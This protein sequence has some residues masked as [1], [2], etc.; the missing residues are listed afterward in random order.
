[1]TTASPALALV[2]TMS[3]VSSGCSV[4]FMDRAPKQP[5]P[6][7]FP[8]C[9]DSAAAP[10]VDFLLAGS[11]LSS[12]LATLADRADS[13]EGF[14]QDDKVAI[15]AFLALSAA[16]IASGIYGLHVRSDC[17]AA[18]S[19]WEDTRRF[20]APHPAPPIPVGSRGG[21]CYGNNT[22]NPGFFCHP[23]AHIC[24][25]GSNG[26]EGGACFADG[27]CSPGLQ[28]AGGLCVRPPPAECRI[29]ANCP[30]GHVCSGGYCTEPPN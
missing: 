18:R 8:V 14:S 10:T 19:K 26:V 9:S 27:S 13:G 24:V 12:G 16:F 4:L 7:N 25:P 30:T 29:D 22:C 28:C 21:R 23:N 20:A 3:M 1:M 11:Y 2:L 6:T 17:T 15:A 5:S